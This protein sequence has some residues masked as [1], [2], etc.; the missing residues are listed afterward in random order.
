MSLIQ[1]SIPTC[2]LID[3][4]RCMSHYSKISD[5]NFKK[6]HASSVQSVFSL[7]LISL[8]YIKVWSCLSS[9]AL[10]LSDLILDSVERFLLKKVPVLFFPS[11]KMPSFDMMSCYNWVPFYFSINQPLQVWLLQDC[12]NF[13]SFWMNPE[14]IY[15][16]TCRYQIENESISL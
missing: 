2:F 14:K 10:S 12:Q 6:Y 5:S 16:E 8:L 13:G 11:Y 15:A 1:N 9:H 3:S 7:L 4:H